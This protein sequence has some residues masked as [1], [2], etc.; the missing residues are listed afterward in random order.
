MFIQ[1][2]QKS[3]CVTFSKVFVTNLK[4]VFMLL[5]NVALVFNVR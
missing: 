5:C 2:S 4:E 1:V 3:V